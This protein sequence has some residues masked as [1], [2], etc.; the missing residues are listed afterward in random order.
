MLN[1][2]LQFSYNNIS[3]LNRLSWIFFFPSESQH[4]YMT[5]CCSLEPDQPVAA[6]KSSAY[7]LFK[8][9]GGLGVE[10]GSHTS[11][12]SLKTPLHLSPLA[13]KLELL[14]NSTC[15]WRRQCGCPAAH[16]DTKL[17]TTDCERR[18]RDALGALS[19]KAWMCIS[20]QSPPHIRGYI[21]SWNT[22]LQST[23]SL[24]FW[25]LSF[26]AEEVEIDW[27]LPQFYF[28]CMGRGM[29]LHP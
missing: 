24:L 3:R 10:G 16:I 25:A 26:Y 21:S 15:R 18:L 5:T 12:M 1:N 7:G 4:L 20:H 8:G 23:N 9:V 22:D 11:S 2:W 28:C 13:I 29:R 27:V 17:L 19:H 14:S 6:S